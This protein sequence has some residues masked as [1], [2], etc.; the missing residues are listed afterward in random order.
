M[1]AEIGRFHNMLAQLGTHL[2]NGS[3][4]HGITEEQLLRGPF[5]NAMTH[6]GQL[7]FLR[8]LAG[9]P[10]P[11]ENFVFAEIRSNHLGED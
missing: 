7:A 10:I 5:A 2:V 1:E 3:P 8:R 6:A 11:P 9:V 4:L